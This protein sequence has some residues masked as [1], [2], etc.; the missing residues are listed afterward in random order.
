MDPDDRCFSLGW[1]PG[2][3][4]APRPTMSTVEIEGEELSPAVDEERAS[5]GN[6]QDEL[7]TWW[8]TVAGDP[9]GNRPRRAR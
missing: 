8:A 7:D 1:S 4:V 5:R 9:V 3:N 6:D 2:G